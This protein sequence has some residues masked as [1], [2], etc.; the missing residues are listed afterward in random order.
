MDACIAVQTEASVSDTDFLLDLASR[1]VFIQGVVGWLDPCV[2]DLEEKLEQYC[3]NNLLKG[4]RHTVYDKKGYFLLDP[5]FQKGVKLFHK[6]G[7]SFDLLVFPYQMNS[8]I[9]LA[10]KLP[11]QQFVLNHLGK[12]EISKG[13]TL[14][15][16][17]QIK[18]LGGCENVSAKLSGMVTGTRN[19]QWKEE[20]LH[21]FLEITTE[22]FGTGRL[23]FGSDW[24]VC[25]CA[26]TYEE[27]LGI[28]EEYFKGFSEQEREAVFGGSAMKVYR[29]DS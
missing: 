28:V 18:R 8:A 3:S 5:K 16:I 7:I 17:R 29:I 22:A 11:E 23:L 1:Y 10:Q 21:P 14:E 4:I 9:E 27:T 26:A 20:D 13:P 6:H 2:A 24:P 15:W 12:P 19:F 25:T